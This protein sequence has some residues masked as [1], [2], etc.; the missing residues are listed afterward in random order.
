MGRPSTASSTDS[1][2]STTRAIGKVA[3]PAS[4][5][6]KSSRSLANRLWAQEQQRQEY[7]NHLKQ[8]SLNHDSSIHFHGK[9]SISRQP[10][11]CPQDL[12]LGKAVKCILTDSAFTDARQIIV[13]KL[14][15]PDERQSSNNEHINTRRDSMDP[16]DEDEAREVKDSDVLDSLAEASPKEHYKMVIRSGAG[17]VS[18]REY[19]SK[20]YFWH[21]EP[22]QGNPTTR[23]VLD[24][25]MLRRSQNLGPPPLEKDCVTIRPLF[26]AFQK[27]PPELR[28]MILTTAA[29]LG[30]SYNLCADDYGTLKVKKDDFRPAISLSNLFR[31]NKNVNMHLIPF[32][33]HS[34]DFHF[35]L[36][37]FTNFLWQS[38]PTKRHEIRRLTFHFGKLALLHC[39]RWLAPDPVFSLFEPPVATNPRALQYFWRCQIQDL[40]KDLHLFSLTFNIKQIPKADL[41]MIV[42][43]MKAAFGSIQ[44]IR[45]IETD[46]NGVA[47]PVELDDERLTGVRRRWTWRELCMQYYEIHRIH[48]YFFKFELLKSQ[49]ED[50]QAFMDKDGEFFE[51]GFNP[52]TLE[53]EHADMGVDLAEKGVKGN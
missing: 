37:G 50:V 13:I 18:A 35:G 42:A 38:G 31:I 28:E 44:Q 40:V 2:R 34:T 9:L 3:P 33:Y 16:C 43:I 12:Q 22:R 46:A 11:G 53:P 29:G 48:S 1:Q 7:F 4:T 15:A 25:Y 6:P 51:K 5:S 41:S 27:L 32:I 26:H 17:W 21:L 30:G 14:F 23:A 49:A 8:W 20:V 24:E 39:I 19:F 45:F 47:R 52:M 36:T 10:T